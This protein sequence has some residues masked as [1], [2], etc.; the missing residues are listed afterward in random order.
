MSLVSFQNVAQLVGPDVPGNGVS[1]F[2]HVRPGSAP[3]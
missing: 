2:E 3:V 1:I